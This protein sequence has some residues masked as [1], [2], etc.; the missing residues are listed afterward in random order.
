MDSPFTLCLEMSFISKQ[1]HWRWM[2]LLD[3]CLGLS[4]LLGVFWTCTSSLVCPY[5]VD[6]HRYTEKQIRFSIT[7]IS[8][9]LSDCEKNVVELNVGKE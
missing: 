2:C 4:S 1:T 5:L 7:V 6:A 3:N 8:I 9:T